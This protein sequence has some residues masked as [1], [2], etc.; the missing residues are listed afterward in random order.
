MLFSD[1]LYSKNE[2]YYMQYTQIRKFWDRDAEWGRKSV[3]LE[4]LDPEW[5]F[6]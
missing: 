6:N 1:L 3:R 5:F 4:E 2:L